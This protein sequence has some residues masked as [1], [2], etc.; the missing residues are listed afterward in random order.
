MSDDWHPEHRDELRPRRPERRAARPIP[1]PLIGGIVLLGILSVVL[2]LLVMGGGLEDPDASTEPSPSAVASDEESAVPSAS[3]AVPSASE[4]AIAS[5]SDAPQPSFV[6]TEVDLDTIVV[7]TVD[8]LSVRAAPG[9]D[10]ERLGSLADG[11]PGF[12]AGG[13]VDAGGYRWYL[14]S[15]LGLPPN[16][17]C[18]GPVVNEPFSCPVWFG[19]V[20]SG[21]PD[22]TAWL[23]SQPQDCADAPFDYEE[24]VIGVT[25]LMRLACFASGPLTFRA[26]WPEVS[27]DPEPEGA[28]PAE[29]APTGWLLCQQLNDKIVMID[30]SQEFGLGLAVSIDPA[31]GVAMPARGTWLELTVHLDDPAAQACGDDATGAMTEDRTPEAWVLFCRSQMVVDSV[32]A[33]DGP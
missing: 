25:D 30:D 31:S 24:S 1:W 26:W 11:T 12:V 15:G 33:V 32:T 9:T 4:A 13:P 20:A 27:G 23:E 5:P 14:V 2:A 19:W 7:T 17:G 22:G 10:A 8:G 21:S 3:P 18:S 29:D 16:T 28:C 6:P